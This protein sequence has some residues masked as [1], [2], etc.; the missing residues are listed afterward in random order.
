MGEEKAD[1]HTEEVRKENGSTATKEIAT[2]N[3]LDEVQVQ[4]LTRGKRKRNRKAQL[5]EPFLANERED[6][7]DPNVASTSNGA[8][9]SGAIKR[10]DLDIE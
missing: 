7:F 1:Q 8:S 10:L 9:N 3:T 5:P 4:S 2:T 6:G